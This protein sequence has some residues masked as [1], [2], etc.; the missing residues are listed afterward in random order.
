[1]GD[2]QRSNPEVEGNAR[3]K[4]VSM[5]ANLLAEVRA[6]GA[7][8][9]IC[10][11][12]PSKLAR[13]VLKNT[14]TKIAHRIVSSD[15]AAALAM[16]MRLRKDQAGALASLATG[17][18]A[19]FSGGDDYPILVAVPPVMEDLPWPTT[20]EVS[21]A[22]VAWLADETSNAETV[23]TERLLAADDWVPTL[24]RMLNV[25]VA[26][27]E[28]AGGAWKEVSGIAA[29]LLPTLSDEKQT[30]VLRHAAKVT[31][32]RALRQR[33][34]LYD[35]SYEELERL[36]NALAPVLDAFAM[37][38]PIPSDSA[39]A[40]QSEKMHRRSRGPLLGCRSSCGKD[41]GTDHSVVCVFRSSA[42]RLAGSSDWLT[43][44]RQADAAPDHEGTKRQL[45]LASEAI[46]GIGSRGSNVWSRRAA[47][48]FAQHM[49]ARD[50]SGHPT[51]MITTNNKLVWS[52]LI[53]S[54]ADEGN[55]VLVE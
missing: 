20:E 42:A 25:L 21:Q 44:W 12:S 19:V 38:A 35:W 29:R 33:G 37:N 34:R 17:T 55:P 41:E 30:T 36:E 28:Q 2:A 32:A 49:M 26:T 7:G 24:D 47:F 50:R 53:L 15:D 3:F 11:Q 46:I 1:L 10:D 54:A 8:L 43:S 14:N 5:F 40:T 52:K 48:C 39:F 23:W 22:S 4:A 45:D 9:I 6:Y 13:D 27:P 18:A 51:S 16:S 31:L